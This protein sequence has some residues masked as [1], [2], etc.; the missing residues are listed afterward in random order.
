[1]EMKITTLEGKESGSVQLSDAI[2]GLE[3]RS[4][5]VQRCV[6]W[7]LAKR[8]RGTHKTKERGEIARTTKKMYGQKAPARRVTARSARSSLPLYR[9]SAALRQLAARQAPGRHAQDQAARRDRPHRQEGVWP[10]GHRPG[11][12][13]RGQRAAVPRRRS[14]LRSGGAQ[15][16]P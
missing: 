15:P 11:P 9:H 13:R 10:E 2:F 3:P 14:R 5:I 6:N 1:M 8:Q 7:Q 12:P 16:R 4:D